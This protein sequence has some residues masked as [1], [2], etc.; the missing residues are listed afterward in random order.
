[1]GGLD[2]SSKG[3]THGVQFALRQAWMLFGSYAPIGEACLSS[4]FRKSATAICFGSYSGKQ[5]INFTVF[6]PLQRASQVLWQKMFRRGTLAMQNG[7]LFE[8]RSRW[9]VCSRLIRS[10]KQV[11]H[12]IGGTTNVHHTRYALVL[13]S[14]QSHSAAS[15][16]LFDMQAERFGRSKLHLTLW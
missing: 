8:T 9:L 6:E 10:R 3:S 15:V 12:R 4:L 1:M 11:W 16:L 13:R 2:A 7:F 14:P 5:D